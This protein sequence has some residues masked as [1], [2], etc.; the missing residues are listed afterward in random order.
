MV[1]L[2]DTNAHGCSVQLWVDFNAWLF[3]KKDCKNYQRMYCTESTYLLLEAFTIYIHLL[4]NLFSSAVWLV[5]YC[6]S[7]PAVY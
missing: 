7:G 6:F 2:V 5:K 4:T 1:L 3:F